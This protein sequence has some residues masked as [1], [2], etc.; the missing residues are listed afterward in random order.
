MLLVYFV[1]VVL[2]NGKAKDHLKRLILLV[3]VGN[4]HAKEA[5]SAEEQKG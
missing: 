3:L 4:G 1:V 5:A 2:G